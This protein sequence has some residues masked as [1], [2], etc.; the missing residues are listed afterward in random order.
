MKTETP[1]NW[2][3][4]APNVGLPDEATVVAALAWDAPDAV[5]QKLCRARA[6]F[7]DAADALAR[8]TQQAAAAKSKLE[9]DLSATDTDDG[10]GGRGRAAGGHEEAQAEAGRAHADASVHRRARP[11]A[12]RAPADRRPVRRRT[13]FGRGYASVPVQRR[14]PDG[15]LRVRQKVIGKD[16]SPR[17]EAGTRRPSAHP[18][19]RAP[20]PCMTGKPFRF[21]RGRT[22][23]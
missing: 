22:A 20:T 3:A 10:D 11:A 5:D 4:V 8:F 16:N 14:S 18:L 9:R 17:E 1:L 23:G 12:R 13:P 19:R 7:A 2:H 15:S 21:V 6:A